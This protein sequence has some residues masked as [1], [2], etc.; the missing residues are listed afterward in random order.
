MDIIYNVLVV[1]GV[2][3]TV[4][5][6]LKLVDIIFI[7][8]TFDFIALIFVIG[9]Y[10]FTIGVVIFSSEVIII[11]LMRN[12]FKRNINESE[13][14]ILEF[15]SNQKVISKDSLN[16]YKNYFDQIKSKSDYDPPSSSKIKLVL[17][18][19]DGKKQEYLVMFKKGKY[20]GNTIWIAKKG[21]FNNLILIGVIPKNQI[22][23][24]YFVEE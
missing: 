23:N 24:K 4:L 8:K 14:I 15:D 3:L 5:A 2:V 19:K 16:F 10:M 7:K 20:Q 11:K 6:I 22:L 18:K 13:K 9:I 12:E 21:W 1:F 17:I